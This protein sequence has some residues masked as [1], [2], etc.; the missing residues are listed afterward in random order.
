MKI[1]ILRE[2]KIPSDNRAALTPV[3]CVEVQEKFPDVEVLIQPS[4]NRCFSSES[5]S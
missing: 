4:N 5:F 2:G 3:Q 1:G